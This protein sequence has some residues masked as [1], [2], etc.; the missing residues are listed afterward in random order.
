MEAKTT[1][2]GKNDI[3]NSNI[4][5]TQDS[6]HSIISTD[7]EKSLISEPVSRNSVISDAGTIHSTGTSTH[8]T[9]STSTGTHTPSDSPKTINDDHTSE[10]ENI[11]GL[12]DGSEIENETPENTYNFVPSTERHFRSTFVNNNIVNV[13]KKRPKYNTFG[14]NSSSTSAVHI[15]TPPINDIERAPPFSN[16]RQFNTFDSIESD[17]DKI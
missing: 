1:K 15:H 10:I 17:E 8:P 9:T 14:S 3:I 6:H 12:Y 13:Y 2:S 5:S 7:L 11:H 4:N 16:N